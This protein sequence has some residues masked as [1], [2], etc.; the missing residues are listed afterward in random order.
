M[1]VISLYKK[2]YVSPKA[3]VLSVVMD[4][5]R[6]GAQ[7]RRVLACR[8]DLLSYHEGMEYPEVKK[9]QVVLFSALFRKEQ[10]QIVMKGYTGIVLLEVNKLAG[11]AEVATIRRRAA[12]APQTLAAFAGLSGL[13]VK[14]LVGFALPGNRLPQTREEA[15]CFHAHAYRQAVYFYQ[16]QLGRA[17]TLKTPVL[18]RGCRLSYDPDLY[19]NPQAAV[20]TMEQPARMPSELNWE[21]AQQER[22][23]PFD[24]LLPGI[25][26]SY[27]LLFLFSTALKEARTFFGGIEPD[28]PAPFLI[29]LA[30]NCYRSGIPE[31]DMV[32]WA[33]THSPLGR[34][35]AVLR[36]IVR[37][38][39]ALEKPFGTKPC[40]HPSQVMA[41]QLEDF[42]SRRYEFRRN[43]LKK[44]VEYHERGV[45]MFGFS[46]VTDEVL[47]SI[48]MQAHAEGLNFWD[49][50]VKRYVFSKR[51]P[52]H[53]PI[54][55]YLAHLPAW[56]GID[57]IRALALTL[58]TKNKHWPD[59]FA[60]WFIGMVAQWQQINGQRAHS[61]V[62]LLT[63]DQGCG[64]STWC[65]QL[66]PRALREYYTDSLDLGN[67]R[68]T[69][70][71]LHRFALI[72]LDEFDSI[73]LT[74]QPYLKHLLQKPEINARR[75]YKSSI[76]SLKRYGVF[77]ATCNNTDLLTDPTGS[78]RFLCIAIEGK[79]DKRL[80]INHD[81]LYAQALAAIRN[82]E[83]YWFDQEEEQLIVSNNS[84]FEQMPVEEQLLLQYFAPADPDDKAGQWLSPILI[85]QRLQELGKVKFSNV[86]IQQ[87][88]RILRKHQIP[89]LHTRHGNVYHV[90]ELGLL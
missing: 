22:P 31:A 10:G 42:M 58:P 67:K 12:D 25:D 47:N 46:P 73:S 68:E 37:N 74:H 80:R 50:D 49:R 26:Q 79:I 64:K 53:N 19:Y 85:I 44:E 17:I 24:R 18:E 57:H 43:E 51:V 38:V 2:N 70:L 34:H 29:R 83:R 62:P 6:S 30:E 52:V 71:A 5:I 66:M 86:H 7:R 41:L 69:E 9:T 88:G 3:G 48:S 11:T 23:N 75:P 28:D 76:Q 59:L 40:V 13:S 15:E 78:R 35:E 1:F 14:I 54:D 8:E 39:Y 32:E 65:R 20:I 89:L 82:G 60:R 63:G 27:R 61:V 56:D 33:M 4:Q 77:I 84:A 45:C 36:E 55:Y 16:M 81:Q 90:R 21:E 87:F 72:N